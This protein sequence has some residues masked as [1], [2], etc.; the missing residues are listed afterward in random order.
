MH[1]VLTSTSRNNLYISAGPREGKDP[2]P[3]WIALHYKDSGNY[4]LP[5]VY[6]RGW[7]TDVDYDGFDWGAAK[8]PFSWDGN[9]KR[10]ADIASFAEAV[11]IEQHGV[12]VRKEDIFEAW[13]LPERR[14]RVEPSLLF[15]L[16][17]GSNAVDAGAALPNL[18]E[19]FAGKAPDL[20]AH[21]SGKPAARYG[22][23]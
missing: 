13:T 17:A 23:R 12:R 21:E 9:K 18:V 10:Y 19:D 16:K 2:E 14:A 4:V 22:P 20:G 8:H 5:P 1:H 3:L 15:T 11:G 7:M 6:A